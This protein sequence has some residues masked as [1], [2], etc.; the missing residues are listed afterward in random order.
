[1]R[2]HAAAARDVDQIG[3]EPDEPSRRRHGFDGGAEGVLVHGGDLRLAVG[4]K[5]HDDAKAVLRNL[6]PQ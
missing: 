2:H 1:M 5:L 3:F 4:Q 6:H